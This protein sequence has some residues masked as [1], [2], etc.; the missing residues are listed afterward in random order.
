MGLTS[1]ERALSDDMVRDGDQVHMKS[2]SLL[3]VV[4][5]AVLGE[6]YWWITRRSASADA[7]EAPTIEHGATS[8]VKA[9]PPRALLPIPEPAPKSEEATA[10]P[11]KEDSQRAAAPPPA[12]DFETRYGKKTVEELQAAVKVL[13]KQGLDAQEALFEGLFPKFPEL[14]AQGKYGARVIPKGESYS[15]APGKG[16][17]CRWVKNE[18]GIE[19]GHYLEFVG[20]EE[21]A[22]RDIY[23][24]Q[25]WVLARIASLTK[26][27]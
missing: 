26:K 24:E 15:T 4:V 3:I 22:T 1:V 9:D 27:D 16:A 17:T 23:A 6:A 13:S 8:N 19:E 11:T 25:N 14:L 20:T 21:P 12:P 10:A 18:Q 7:R 2:R 5:L